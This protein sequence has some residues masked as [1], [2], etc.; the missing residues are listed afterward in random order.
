MDIASLAN[1]QLAAR[2]AETQMA[3]AA[4]LIKM[5][6]DSSA[7]VAALI[8]QASANLETLAKSALPE[9]VGGTVDISV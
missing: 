4:K 9:G 3:V 7:S 8:D 5:N 6:A 1:G 2:Q